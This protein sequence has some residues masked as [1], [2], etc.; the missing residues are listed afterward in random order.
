MDNDISCTELPK[1]CRWFAPLAQ[2]LTVTAIVLTATYVMQQI[3]IGNFPWWPY[4]AFTLFT[5]LL[6]L[7]HG[8]VSRKE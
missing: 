8:F 5:A 7:A 1:S 6:F 3:N 2:I 4:P